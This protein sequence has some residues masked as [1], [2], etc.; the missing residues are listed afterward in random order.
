MSRALT[1]TVLLGTFAATALSA[2]LAA[3]RGA[4]PASA[5]QGTPRL[6]LPLRDGWRFL[7]GPSERAWAAA[8]DDSAWETVTLPHTW[9]AHDGEDGGTYYQGDGWYRTRFRL[10]A[11]WA[12]KRVYVQFDG[13]NRSAEVFVNGH[14]LGQHRGGFARFRFDITSVLVPRGDNVLAVRVNND[15]HDNIPPVSADFTF[16]GGLYRAASLLATDPVHI[17]VL[18]HASP[19]VFVRQEHATPEEAQLEWHVKLANDTERDVDATVQTS[20]FDAAGALVETAEASLALPARGREDV[21]RRLIVKEPQ[22]WDAQARPN[23]YRLRADLRVG[24]VV[25]D[26]VTLRLGLRFF[27]VDPARGFL[28]NGHALDLHGVNRHQ[29]RP[30]KGWAIS[31]DDEREDFAIAEELGATFVRQSHYQQSQLWN[32]LADEHGMVTWAEL[33]YVNDARD[34]REFCENAKEQLRELIR[35]NLHHPSILFWSIG[36]ETFVRDTKVMP[37][38]AND[39]LLR[40]LA[41]VVRE[42]DPTRLSTYASN[43]SV[44]EPRAGVTDV[45]GFNHYFGWYHDAPEDLAAWIDAQHALRPDLRIGFSEYGAGANVEHHEEPAVRPDTRGPWHPEE[46]QSIYHEVHWRAMAARPWLWCKLIWCLFDFASDGRN[47]GGVPGR[48]DKGLVTADRKTRK[49]AFYWYQANWSASPVLHIASRRFVARAKPTTD[50]KVYSNAEAVELF[51]NDVSV[52]S[53]TRPDRLFLWTGVTLAPGRNLIEARASRD[54]RD[55]VDRC[56]WT[57]TPQA[58]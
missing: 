9:N 19:G 41:A 40:E 22:L 44:S 31:E 18:D 23:L 12:R 52:G 37:A 42:E 56:E 3:P 6:A 25:R 2:T 4:T 11:T 38:D 20:L 15:P 51:V 43:G 46:W 29:D 7:R 21:R 50:I 28:L 33:A 54:G 13:A 16:F 35:Q 26:T 17:D 32:D 24:G 30:G 45:L 48:N 49:D 27:S 58:P 39:R 53:L 57:L 34:N 1:L 10:P 36:N 8:F 14:R 55:L 47:E 5:A